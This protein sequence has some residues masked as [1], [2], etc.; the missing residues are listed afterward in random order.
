MRLRRVD[1][2]EPGIRRVRRGRGFSLVSPDG[3][4]VSDPQTLERVRALAIPPAW[5]DVWISTHPRGHLQATGIDAAGRKQYLYHEAW[6]EQRD[7]Q[8]FEH[9]ENFAHALPRLRRGVGAELQDGSEPTHDHVAAC[10]VRLLDVG[11]FRVGGE[12][13]AD[14][15]GGI[16]LATLKREHLTLDGDEAVFDYP[17]KSGVRR[18]HSVSDPGCVEFLRRL[19]R[20][21]GGPDELL[22]FKRGRAWQPLGSD[23]INRHIKSIAGEDFSA[24]DFR[25]WNA[26]VLAAVGLAVAE[27][28]NTKTNRKRTVAAVVRDVSEALGN[29][30]AVA[31]R[32]YVDPRVIDHYLAGSTIDVSPRATPSLGALTEGRRRSLELAVLRLLS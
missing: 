30:P 3:V 18:H 5:K 2:S 7:L 32:A 20:R 9:I 21:R 24:K 6:R 22:V 17:G 14:E 11:L 23:A 10:A 31:R 13:Y 1:S 16:G 4:A 15:E 8:K 26:T 12:D 25:T 27:H 28:R 29:T 19:R